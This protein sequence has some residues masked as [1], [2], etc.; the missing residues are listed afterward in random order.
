MT[1]PAGGHDA[2]RLSPDDP[3]SCRP[4]SIHGTPKARRSP[5]SQTRLTG[6]TRTGNAPN[7]TGGSESGAPRHYWL[8]LYSTSR[9]GGNG[10]EHATEAL[11]EK[12]KDKGRKTRSTVPS[13]VAVSGA[14]TIDLS[15]HIEQQPGYLARV[16][17]ELELRRSRRWLTATTLLAL[18]AALTSAR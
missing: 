7:Q 15:R 14:K 8:S 13:S 11:E 5:R 6:Q 17:E 9:R 16:R 12:Y 10:V 2:G 18:A 1:Q 3:T 4:G